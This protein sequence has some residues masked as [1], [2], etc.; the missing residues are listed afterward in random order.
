LTV[1][2]VALTITANNATRI[3]GV[4]NPT[5]TASYSG[6]VLADGPAVLGGT[7]SF[8]TLA[9]A[10]SAPGSYAITP[11]GSTSSDYTIA[12]TPGILT[13]TAAPLSGTGQ[14]ITPTAGAPFSGIVARFTNADPFGGPGSYTAT[15]TWGDGNTSTGTITDQGGGTFAVSGANTFATA[16][17][18]TVRVQISHNRGYTTTATTTATA[19]VT[20]LGQGVVP[21]LT[22]SMGFWQN[23]NGQ[24]LITS[25][26][27]GATATALANWLALTFP[28]LYGASAG[29]NNLAGKSN[30]Q[31]AAFYLTQFNLSGPKVEAQ[32]LAVALNVYATTAALGGSAGTSYGFTVSAAG[33]GARSFNV[34]GDGAAFGV[35]NNTTLNVYQLLRA[36]NQQ[37]VGSVLYNGNSQLRGQAADLFG[38]LDQAGT[39]G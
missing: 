36:V 39:I 9:V 22:G 18:F 16:G 2:P 21:G 24:A 34:G 33:L 31:V 7:S 6:W 14:T 37:A 28:N 4:P 32:T 30:A 3:Y 19:A 1:T 11:S 26:N 8:S 10:S 5:F 27:G 13:V 25:F 29:G 35:A 12:F 15:I 20:N 23:S 17:S 38:N